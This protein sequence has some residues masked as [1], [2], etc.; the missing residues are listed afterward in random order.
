MDLT[1]KQYELLLEAWAISQADPPMGMVL[2]PDCFPDA[3]ELAEQGWLE[4]KFVDPAGDMSWHW[5]R[6]ADAAFDFS[7]LLQSAAGRQN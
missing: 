5:T 4:R 2:K 3:H 7:D 1:D 6:A